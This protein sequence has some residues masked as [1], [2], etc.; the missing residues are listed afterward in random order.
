MGLHCRDNAIPVQIDKRD[1]KCFL[2]N[3]LRRFPKKH[4]HG[5]MSSHDLLLKRRV[6]FRTQTRFPRQR[7]V[8][9]PIA[10]P[11]IKDVDDRGE[12]RFEFW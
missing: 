8:L 6:R 4:L 2:G 11:G 10:G 12:F 5:D 7:V 9:A 1:G 3:R